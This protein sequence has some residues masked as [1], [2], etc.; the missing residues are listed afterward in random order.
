[1]DSLFQFIDCV[2]ANARELARDVRSGVIPIQF[3]NVVIALGNTAKLDK[4]TDVPGAVMKIV[5]AL[6]DRYGSIN[7]DISVLS[8]LL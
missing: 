5:G 6:V 8:L 4:F 7:L 3:G 1:M 2:Q